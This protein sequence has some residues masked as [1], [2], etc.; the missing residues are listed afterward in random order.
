MKLNF[1]PEKNVDFITH[2]ELKSN[3]ETF[4]VPIIVLGPRPLI[5]VPDYFELPQTSPKIL[6]EQIAFVKNIGSVEAAFSLSI[7]K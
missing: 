5:N 1:C 4:H 7:K 6:S 2:I 3:S